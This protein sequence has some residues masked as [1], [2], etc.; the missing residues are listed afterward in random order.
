MAVSNLPSIFVSLTCVGFLGSSA[1]EME[2]VMES[3]FGPLRIFLRDE[4]GNGDI[5]VG[6]VD[7]LDTG[8]RD[9]ANHPVHD[10]GRSSHA[11][12]DYRDLGAVRTNA[13]C[14]VQIA[15]LLAHRLAVLVI[16]HEKYARGVD[17][18]HVDRNAAF[19]DPA[20]Q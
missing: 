15:Q 2:G 10:A 5:R 11:R 1:P 3:L 8:I 7:D 9:G 19:G 13:H 4:Y 6:R 14:E 17:I 16:A 20:Q 12:T 18:D